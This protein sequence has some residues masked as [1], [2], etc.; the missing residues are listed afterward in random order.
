MRFTAVF[1]FSLLLVPLANAVILLP[2]KIENPVRADAIISEKYKAIK[3]LLEKNRQ[4]IREKF[5]QRTLQTSSKVLAVVPETASATTVTLSGPEDRAEL[6][7]ITGED[8]L[9]NDPISKGLSEIKDTS[10]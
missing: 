7:P 3:A 4:K 1:L 6:P 2:G 9:K 8:T 5:S 10:H